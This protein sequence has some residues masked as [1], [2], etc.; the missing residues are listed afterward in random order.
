ML[1]RGVIIHDNVHLQ[2]LRHVLFNLPEKTQILLMSVTRSTF[3]EHI[4]V[5]RVSVG[6]ADIKFLGW[7]E[8][9]AVFRGWRSVTN[10]MLVT[11]LRGGMHL[12]LANLPGF[13][14]KSAPRKFR[15][16]RSTWKES[17]HRVIT[18]RSSIPHIN[19]LA[20]DR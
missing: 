15:E 10:S 8:R 16:T 9:S 13:S 19:F 14:Y 3:R 12:I 7:P 1:V 5:R 2:V 4:A 11:L 20:A 18:S 17:S 6:L